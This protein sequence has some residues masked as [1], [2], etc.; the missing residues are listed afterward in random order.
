MS[1]GK[2]IKNA[3]TK[4]GLKQSELAAA[5]KINQVTISKYETDFTKNPRSNI[6]FGIAA[7]LGT[8]PEYLQFGTTQKHI[9]DTV[10]GVRKLLD[11]CVGLS[12]DA[13]A[14]LISVAKTLHE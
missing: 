4:L 5:V 7:A 13:I 6:M 9:H 2:R 12:P 10:G 1:M 14:K 8:T 11:V 3:R